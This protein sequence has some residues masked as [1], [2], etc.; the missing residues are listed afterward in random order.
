MGLLYTFCGR[1]IDAIWDIINSITHIPLAPGWPH[2]DFDC[3]FKAMTLGVPLAGHFSCSYSSVATCNIYNNHLMV[4]TP[5]V[6]NAIWKK[7]IKEEN[8]SYNVIFQHWLWQ[9]I[10]GLFINPLTSVLPKFAGNL[11]CIC[12]DGTNMIDIHNDG[13]PNQQIPKPGTPSWLDENPPIDYGTAFIQ[14]LIWIYNLWV[15]H[16]AE[17]ILMIPDDISSAFHQI[18]YHPM[19]MPVF[20]SVLHHISASQP[21]ASLAAAMSMAFNF[22]TMH[23]QLVGYSFLQAVPSQADW[24]KFY[25]TSRCI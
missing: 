4:K 15:D 21:A 5:A 3:T 12:I 17:D 6:D 19:M 9:F 7:S 1:E 10:L 8:L 2:I 14:C 20:A 18:F 22:S 11:G 25:S 23:A 13:T 24:E 16:P